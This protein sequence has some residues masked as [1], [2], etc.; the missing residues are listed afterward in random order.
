[1]PGQFC[2]SSAMVTNCVTDPPRCF[3]DSLWKVCEYNEGKFWTPSL[4]MEQQPICGLYPS[5]AVCSLDVQERVNGNGRGEE[6][7]QIVEKAWSD[8][9]PPTTQCRQCLWR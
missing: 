7:G 2:E 1:M 8:C 3:C 4:R 9:C 6:G 5:L